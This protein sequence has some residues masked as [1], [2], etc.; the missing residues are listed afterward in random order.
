MEKDNKIEFEPFMKFV[1]E[2]HNAS[3]F[4]NQLLNKIVI[5]HDEFNEKEIASIEEAFLIKQ[6]A[7]W[8]TFIQ[9]VIIYCVAI[10][11][12]KIS[13]YLDLRLPKKVSFEN[14]FAIVNGLNYLSVS[15]SSELKGLAK[16]IITENNNPFEQFEIKF[17]KKIDEAYVLRNY[18]AHKSKKSKSSLLKMYLNRYNIN[19]FIVPGQ[20]LSEKIKDEI[21]EYP[22]SH[23]YYGT[24]MTIATLVW[25]HLDNKSYSFVFVDDKSKEGWLDG[26]VKMN[27]I[28]E[29][30][31]KEYNL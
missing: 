17:L 5:R 22:R 2:F 9:N 29:I 18:I 31:S 11:T 12:S 23:L 6:I 24:F 20:F 10:D 8:E 3:L 15:S 1:I 14:S 7:E 28:F 26:L 25:K 16:K 21:G 19:Y 27:R 13:E 4:H 30:M